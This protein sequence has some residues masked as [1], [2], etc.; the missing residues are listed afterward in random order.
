MA[1]K[2]GR[3]RTVVG[4]GAHNSSYFLRHFSRLT[5]VSHHLGGTLGRVLISTRGAGRGTLP[6]APERP[7]QPWEKLAEQGPIPHWE[8]KHH[9]QDALGADRASRPGQLGP[10]P[11]P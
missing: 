9:G 7:F 2:P 1:T 5:W 4:Q 8:Y 6:C 10:C 11:G 3:G